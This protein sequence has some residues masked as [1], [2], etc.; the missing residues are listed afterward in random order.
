MP[1]KGVKLTVFPLLFN[2]LHKSECHQ[3]NEKNVHDGKFEFV[4]VTI[5]YSS[6]CFEQWEKP[7]ED[8]KNRLKSFF[9]LKGVSHF[10]KCAHPFAS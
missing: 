10:N 7:S 9:S 3:N 4:F 1:K 5:C 2:L 8:K 6:L